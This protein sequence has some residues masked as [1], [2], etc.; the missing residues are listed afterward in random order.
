MSKKDKTAFVCTE[1]GADFPRWGGQ[2]TSCGAWNT[3]KE[4]RLGSAGTTRTSKHS[5]GY[6]GT[7]SEVKFLSDVALAH[8]ERI[9]T[10][11]SEFDRVLGGGITRGSV[12]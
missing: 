7:R 11:M 3:I 6:S 9:S 2:C 12:Y 10:G 5:S 8:E 1:C 4:V